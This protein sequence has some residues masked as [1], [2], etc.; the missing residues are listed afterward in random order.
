MSDLTDSDGF[1][2]DDVA[3]AMDQLADDEIAGISD[4]EQLMSLGF[5][6]EA[7]EQFYKRDDEQL[8][9]V[10]RGVILGGKML[11]PTLLKEGP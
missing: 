8:K 9:N 5:S 7:A 6:R 2:K 11:V 3:E 1:Q 10:A 4:I